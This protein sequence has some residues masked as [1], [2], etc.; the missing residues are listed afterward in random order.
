[1]AVKAFLFDLNGTMIDDMRFHI[2]AWHGILNSLGAELSMERARLECYGKNDE[3]LE[4]IFPGRFSADEK[5]AMGIAKERQY[6]EDFRPLLKLIEGLPQFLEKARER[7]I[8]MAIGSAAIMFNVDFVLDGLD[9]RRYFDTIVSAD[10]VSESKPDPETWLACADL[11]N[12]PCSD[13][14]VFED[15]PKGVE[16][17]ERAG[18]HSIAITT[19]HSREEFARHPNIRFCIDDYTDPQLDRLFQ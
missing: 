2:K 14:L 16:A 12:I 15:S 18:M 19:L 7:G 1:M 17:A 3:L 11:L 13:C 4:R 5:Q 9:L 6:Q 8:R 10:H